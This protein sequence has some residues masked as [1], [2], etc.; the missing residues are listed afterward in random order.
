[1]SNLAIYEIQKQYKENPA[2]FDQAKRSIVE[3]TDDEADEVEEKEDEEAAEVKD[4]SKL[5]FF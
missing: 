3:A 1:M 2:Y 4:P 5:P